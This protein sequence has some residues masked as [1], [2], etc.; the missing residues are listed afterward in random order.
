MAAR[1]E[2]CSRVHPPCSASLLR[3]TAQAW[4]LDQFGVLHDGKKAYPEAVRACEEREGGREGGNQGG[5]E[6]GR[7]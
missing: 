6:P 2:A 3:L 5:R 1:G 7:G 4:I